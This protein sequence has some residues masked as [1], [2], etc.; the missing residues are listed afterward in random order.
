MEAQKLASQPVAY[1]SSTLIVWESRKYWRCQSSGILPRTAANKVWNHSKNE[2]DVA[3]N[4]AGRKLENPSDKEFGSLPSRFFPL[5][6]VHYA[7]LLSLGKVVNCLRQTDSKMDC[8]LVVHETRT[9]FLL[10]R[11]GQVRYWNKHR[12][13]LY[14]RDPL[15]SL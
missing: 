6:L 14:K 4:K 2:K 15:P 7:S 8:K 3:I 9:E 11:T 13:I 1:E 10:S 12:L 5:A